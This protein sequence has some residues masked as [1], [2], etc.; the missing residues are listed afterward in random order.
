M[1]SEAC[2]SLDLTRELY[3]NVLD[4]HNSHIINTSATDGVESNTCRT[5][6]LASCTM[7]E[8]DADQS[9]DF[10]LGKE[11]IGE[12]MY[13]E[14]GIAQVPTSEVCVIFSKTESSLLKKFANHDRDVV[15]SGPMDVAREG[16]AGGY[17]YWTDL[18]F[19]LK[20]T[21]AR[22]L[23]SIDDIIA[24]VTAGDAMV[25]RTLLSEPEL[26]WSATLEYPINYVN[27][28]P[29]AKR[30]QVDV[31]PVLY[32]ELDS[33]EAFIVDRVRLAYV[34][35]NQFDAVEFAIREQTALNDDEQA[36]T[37]HYSR[38]V[39]TAAASELYSLS[40]GGT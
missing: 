33:T 16:F 28:H 31:G 36:R 25:G 8:T 30:F 18:Q 11:C 40:N 12:H 39:K 3:M 9:Y 5:Q 24:A 14:I 23:D 10:Y 22:R 35:F 15:Q 20:S 21:Q 19:M 13:K 34:M 1:L 32:P 4:Y 6:V 38:V 26:G 29:P 27:V 2:L 7:T 17:A 37:L